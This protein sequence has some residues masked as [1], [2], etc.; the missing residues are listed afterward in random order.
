M[1]RI[2]LFVSFLFLFC[3]FFVSF[4]FLFCFFFVSFSLFFSFP[5]LFLLFLFVFYGKCRFGI[6][7]SPEGEKKTGKKETNK[8]HPGAIRFFFSFCSFF[9]CFCFLFVFLLFYGFLSNEAFCVLNMQLRR[10]ISKWEQ[11]DVQ[12]VKTFWVKTCQSPWTLQKIKKLIS[13]P[14]AE[15][16]GKG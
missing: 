3:F 10:R 4:L 5:F 14:V 2:A 13:W 8:R 1:T 6:P 7:E 15:S 11:N 16:K 12:S 9:V